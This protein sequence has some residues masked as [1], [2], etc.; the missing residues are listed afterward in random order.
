MLRKEQKIF[1]FAE[2][3]RLTS[4]QV[5]VLDRVRKKEVHKLRVTVLRTTRRKEPDSSMKIVAFWNRVP[6]SLVEVDWC[7]SC[8]YCL[9]H[10]GCL[11][12]LSVKGWIH[13]KSKSWLKIYMHCALY[14][15]IMNIY[16]ACYR[17]LRSWSQNSGPILDKFDLIYRQSW[18]KVW[19]DM[20]Q[21]KLILT[22]PTLFLCSLFDDAFSVTKII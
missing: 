1:E 13:S 10:L 3:S 19:Y 11:A 22:V 5:H 12:W 21:S 18:H 16:R 14:Q 4:K 9:H 20:K 2:A 8:T 7:F 15:C 17:Q 6:C